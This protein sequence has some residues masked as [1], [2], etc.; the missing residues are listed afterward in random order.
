VHARESQ[1]IAILNYR[2]GAKKV[3][4]HTRIASMEGKKWCIQQGIWVITGYPKEDASEENELPT[5]T[6]EAK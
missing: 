6:Y 1:E 5:T 4:Y 3:G 2:R